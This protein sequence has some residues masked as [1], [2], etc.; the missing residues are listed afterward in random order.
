[1][2]FVVPQPG[3]TRGPWWQPVRDY[4]TPTFRRIVEVAANASHFE[5]RFFSVA[6]G[7]AVASFLFST[8]T[9]HLVFF[10]RPMCSLQIVSIPFCHWEPPVRWAD[11]PTLVDLQAR[12]SNQ[13]LDESVGYERFV[14]EVKNA[15]RV[16]NN[17]IV[18]VGMSDLDNKTEIAERL[19]TL[20]DDLR[21]A[22]KGLH[23]LR[24]K[25]QGAVNSYVSPLPLL[26]QNFLISTI[27]LGSRS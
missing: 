10:A 2:E 20:A 13:L 4:A 22:G 14:L 1:M 23:S 24:G 27:P 3:P 16:N 6:V 21:V 19:G 7:I 18:L 11:Y 12:Y 9:S 17:L 5:R 26:S 25:I 8:V 15:E